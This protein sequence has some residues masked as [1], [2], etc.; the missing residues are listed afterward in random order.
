MGMQVDM[1]MV[2]YSDTQALLEQCSNE[3]LEPLVEYILKART[4]SLSKY[5]DFKRWHP[6]H[7][8]YVSAIFDEL[9]RFGGNSF[10]NLGRKEGPAYIEVVRDVAK[11]FKIKN[12]KAAGVVELEEMLLQAVLRQAYEKSSPEERV[13]LEGVLQEAG[14][15]ASKISALQQ[16]AAL[17]ALVA[18]AVAK[19]VLYRS[20]VVIAHTVA[21]QMLG[22][23]VRYSAAVG[24]GAAGLKALSV[25][26]GPVGWAVAGVWGAADIAGPAYRITIPC[27]LHIA[28]LRLNA[29]TA[30]A[31]AFMEG[32][33]DG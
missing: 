31:T 29:E 16:G 17:S 15:D 12:T 28:M 23:G 26:A 32:A 24:A 3:Q 11:K 30:D 21:R 8:R 19:V 10:I 25:L 14:L 13:E 4:E 18:P 20:S 1:T 2:D 6:N 7:Q 27:A 33:F 22:H 9:R 5:S